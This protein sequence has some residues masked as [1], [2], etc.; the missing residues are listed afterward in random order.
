MFKSS[1]LSDET[2]PSEIEMTL[3]DEPNWMVSYRECVNLLKEVEFL[4]E[5]SV[6]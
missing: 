4:G 6:I 2:R 3:W 1:L 5:I